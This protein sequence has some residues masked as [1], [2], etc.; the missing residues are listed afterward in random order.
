MIGE[1]SEERAGPE[2]GELTEPETVRELV[3]EDRD[4]IVQWPVV[5]VEAKVEV[6]V[7]AEIRV[8]VVACRKQVHARELVRERDV[9]PGVG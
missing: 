4:E 1:A 8:D 5:V 2:V 9:I 3:Q 6:E 7:G